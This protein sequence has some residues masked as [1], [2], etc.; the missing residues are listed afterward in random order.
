[1]ERR[2]VRGVMGDELVTKQ[3]ATQEYHHFLGV[4]GERDSVE[5]L[6]S[7][8]CKLITVSSDLIPKELDLGKTQPRLRK[9]EEDIVQDAAVQNEFQ[10]VK[11][12]V[13]VPPKDKNVV[14]YDYHKVA[15][16]VK[17]L[18]HKLVQN[19]RGL[20]YAFRHEYWPYLSPGGLH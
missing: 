16:I 13:V 15:I 6:Q 2:G 5:R 8:L 18:R 19:S 20:W 11:K 4:L 12:I 7:L 9:F 3:A 10:F 17:D 14:E 1:M